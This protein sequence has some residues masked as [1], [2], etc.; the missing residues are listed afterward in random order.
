MVIK[1]GDHQPITKPL[2]ALTADEL[3]R[4]LVRL[5]ACGKAQRLTAGL[6]AAEAAE[7]ELQREG[8]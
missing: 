4:L 2:A 7:R 3:P 1:P 8:L 5:R 6:T